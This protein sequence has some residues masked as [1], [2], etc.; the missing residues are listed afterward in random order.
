LTQQRV[1][2]HWFRS[3]LRLHDNPAL[4]DALKLGYSV[5]PAFIWY[6]HDRWLPGAAS[7]VWLHYSLKSLNEQLCALGSRLIIRCGSPLQELQKLCE[8][9]RATALFCNRQYEPGCAEEDE[10]ANHALAGNHIEFHSYCSNLLFEP[11]EVSTK[12]NTPYR[13]YTPFANQLRAR[14]DEIGNP[15]P[16]ATQLARV[17]EKLRSISVQELELLPKIRWHERILAHWTPGE[18]A[19]RARLKAITRK[20]VGEYAEER[21]NPAVDGTSALSPH[22]HFGEISP[23][24]VL[25][26][27]QQV[28]KRNPGA[29]TGADTLIGE[30]VWREFAYHLLHHFPQTTGQPLNPAYA[31]FPWRRSQRDLL[32]WQRGLTGYPIVDAGMRQLW[33]TGWMHNRVRLIVASFLVKDLLIS[34]REGAHWFWDTL[35]D[36]DLANNTMNWQW[37]AGCGADAAPFFRIFNPVSQGEKFDPGGEYVRRFVPEIAT[38][39][40]RY[41]HQPWIAPEDVLENAQIELGRNY[42]KPIVDHSFA[43]E[44]ALQAL[45]TLRS[46]G[47]SKQKGSKQ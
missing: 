23:R 36:A 3:D 37:I 10:K 2:V 9:T 6:P 42:P 18:P 21:N 29:A 22:L 20:I 47:A 12:T 46:R 38:L 17:P 14:L 32:A 41:I 11:W 40:N 16:S 28:R 44:R 5:V 7:Q 33:Q 26:A 43:R 31:A 45:G 13:V 27:A 1:A 8:E 19:A 34:W 24:E 30:L 25:H 39:P 15:L 35:F 4:H